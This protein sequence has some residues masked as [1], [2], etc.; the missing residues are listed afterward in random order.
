M[1]N[2]EDRLDVQQSYL[3]GLKTKI[4][5]MFQIF[6]LNLSQESALEKKPVMGELSII[7]REHLCVCLCT[8]IHT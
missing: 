5:T 7:P 4:H 8:Y 1:G 6:L 2:Q 3:H